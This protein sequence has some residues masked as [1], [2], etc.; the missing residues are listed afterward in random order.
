MIGVIGIIFV[1]LPESPWWLVSKGRTEKAAKVLQQCNGSV[2]GY[3]VQ[4]QLVRIPD[5]FW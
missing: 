5:S 1:G 3:D 4:E 2:K